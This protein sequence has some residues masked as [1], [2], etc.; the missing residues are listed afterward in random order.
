MY[1]DERGWFSELWTAQ[2]THKLSHVHQVSVSL[3]K[4]N[5]FRGFHFQYDPPMDKIMRVAKG[6]AYLYAVD[7]RPTSPDFG[8]VFSIKAEEA[9]RSEFTTTTF[10]APYWCARGFLALEDGTQI[11][12]LQSSTHNQGSAVTISWNDPQLTNFF[13]PPEEELIM[14][15]KD[16]SYGISLEKW[17][18]ICPKGFGE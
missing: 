16:K 7:V 12:Y 18:E 13:P 6:S 14:S 17:K 9:N 8:S 3:S 15:T 10:F 11:E 5:V 2:H 1:F 4:K